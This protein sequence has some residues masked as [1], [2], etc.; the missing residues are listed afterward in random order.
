M[1]QGFKKKKNE[2]EYDKYKEKRPLTNS[3]LISVFLQNTYWLN[4][5]A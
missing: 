3:D 1:N 4:I 2:P 5:F